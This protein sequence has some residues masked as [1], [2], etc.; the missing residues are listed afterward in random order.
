[1]EEDLYGDVIEEIDWSVGQIIS[2]L[3]K[4]NKLNNTDNVADDTKSIISG[5]DL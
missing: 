5:P 3:K 4:L 2:K 1:M